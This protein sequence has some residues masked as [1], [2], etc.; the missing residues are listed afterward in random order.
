MKYL[1]AAFSIF[2]SLNVIAQD[3][4]LL[5]SAP[6]DISKDGWNKLLQFKNGNTALFHFEVNKSFLIKVFD[7][8]GKEIAS[9]KYLPTIVDPTA[10]D[11]AFFDGLYDINGE[12]V[13]FITQDIDNVQ[14]LVRLRF[15]AMNAGIISEERIV[16]SD[17]FNKRISAYVL[18]H[19]AS[20][21]YS[22][23]CYMDLQTDTATTV[24]LI[25]YNAKHEM[26]KEIPY[27]TTKKGIDEVSFVSA[28]I[29]IN[30]NI[31]AA[32]QQSKIVQYPALYDRTLKILYMP[33]NEDKFIPVSMSVENGLDIQS[34][35]HTVNTFAENVNFITSRKWHVYDKGIH[36]YDIATQSMYIF[37]NDFSK[38]NN[39]SFR[40]NLANKILREVSGDS[41]SKFTGWVVAAITNDRGITTIISESKGIPRYFIDKWPNNA[42]M[43]SGDICITQLDDLGNEMWAT[44]VPK[45]NY[46]IVT[47]TF[48]AVFHTTSRYEYYTSTF[49]NTP[50]R[51]Y[52]LFNTTVENYNKSLNQKQADVF[53]Y[54]NTNAIL[55]CVGK[56]NTVVKKYLVAGTEGESYTI[57]PRSE[58]FRLE[59]NKL[60]ILASRKKD[61]KSTF[62]IAWRKME[63]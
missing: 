17:N 29:D 21:D 56:K 41:N 42:V 60:A 5:I 59:N 46:Y 8:S 16:K 33:A 30:G 13:L 36:Q 7:A 20:D 11:K 53:D 39:V 38:V 14:T 51:S 15:N 31:L 4:T 47:E 25:K 10:L 49:V 1:I 37:P 27:T 61:S 3:S 52:V 9:K 48:P 43:A 23:F 63:D 19:D 58:H 40:Y 22:I 32:I 57:L 28:D 44:I 34:G 50:K 26:I 55:Y 24:K 54:E 45:N 6:I 62:H 12:A 18:K 35:R 2:L